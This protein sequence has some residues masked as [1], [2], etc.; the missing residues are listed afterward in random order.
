MKQKLKKYGKWGLYAYL[1]YNVIGLI[2]VIFNWNS[3]M[4]ESHNIALQIM[5]VKN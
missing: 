2:V 5:G 1:A 4:A 3:L